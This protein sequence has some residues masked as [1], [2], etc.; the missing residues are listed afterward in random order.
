[1]KIKNPIRTYL[2]WYGRN[3]IEISEEPTARALA[4]YGTFSAKIIGAGLA[5]GA[6]TYGAIYLG[7]MIHDKMELAKY[8]KEKS[9]N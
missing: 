7:M 9:E 6:V 2:N 8:R 5:V 4:H 1:M 3:W